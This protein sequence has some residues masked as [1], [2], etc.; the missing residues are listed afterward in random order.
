MVDDSSCEELMLRSDSV[1]WPQGRTRDLNKGSYGAVYPVKVHGFTCIAKR[2]HDVL[3]DAGPA[4]EGVVTVS[5][6]FMQECKILS[7]LHHP[8]IVQF[9]GIHR[10]KDSAHP[11]DVSLIMEGLYIDLEQF[12]ENH[13]QAKD[14]VPLFLKL[15][16]LLDT[17]HALVYLHMHRPPI[18]HRDVKAANVLLARD[19]H[20]KL[21]DLGTS[22]LLAF[23]PL[24]STKLTNCP[25]TLGIM[26]P[27]ALQ[28]SPAY[29]TK[30]DVFSYGTLI[31]HT[32]NQEFPLP[33]EVGKARRRGEF[34]ITKRQAAMD[35]L[36]SKHRQLHEMTRKC[37]QDN[38][39]KRPEMKYVRDELDRLSLQHP[40]NFTTF[41]DMYRETD[42][43]KRVHIMPIHIE[44]IVATTNGVGIP[45]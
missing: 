2:L 4:D 36:S 22:K 20:A 44:Y 6:K 17:S 34:Q 39:E 7:T 16:F 28:P 43:L 37:L 18:I 15:S 1:S 3:Q 32:L 33:C 42:K 41:Y 19:M 25:G 45:L 29:N 12:L 27:E 30:L 11:R 21:A 13:N 38:P 5:E 23:N 8:N 31:L 35:M 14:T 9:M 10:A 26:P 24:S 40:C